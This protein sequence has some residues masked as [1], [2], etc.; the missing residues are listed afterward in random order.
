MKTNESEKININYYFLP[1][2]YVNMFDA[3]KYDVGSVNGRISAYKDTLLLAQNNLIAGNGYGYFEKNFENRKF[4]FNTIEE[5]IYVMKLL[6]ETGIV[7]LVIFSILCVYS[8][9]IIC[10]NIKNKNILLP[11]LLFIVILLS[12][13]VDFTMSYNFILLIFLLSMYLIKFNDE[14]NKPIV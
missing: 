3:L 7:V 14:N 9:I 6:L 10:K 1:T 13:I 4:N 12:A 2:F 8:F 5:H 11:T